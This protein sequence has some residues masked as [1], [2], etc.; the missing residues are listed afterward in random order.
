MKKVFSLLL[1]VLV[2]VSILG[3]RSAY[4]NDIDYEVQAI[5]QFIAE[6]STRQINA[7]SIRNL[8]TNFGDTHYYVV[9]CHSYRY[10]DFM[11][12]ASMWMIPKGRTYDVVKGLR[13]LHT[14]SLRIYDSAGAPDFSNVYYCRNHLEGSY[15]LYV[16]KGMASDIELEYDGGDWVT[17]SDFFDP[18]DNI[19]IAITSPRDGFKD[20]VNIFAI[21]M[22]YE[23]LLQS[24]QTPAEN[25]SINVFGG[26]EDGYAEVTHHNVRNVGGNRWQGTLKVNMEMEE[27]ENEITARLKYIDGSDEY[28]AYDTKTYYVY[29]GVV[30]ED[31]DGIDDRTGQPV[32][33]PPEASEY[34]LTAPQ[35]PEGSGI[36]GY[37]SWFFESIFWVLGM[38]TDG[39][40]RLFQQIGSFTS[41]VAEFFDFLPSEFVT[42]VFIGIM[43]SIVLRVVGR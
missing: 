18:L 38:I 29:S 13:G 5:Q 9:E 11:G 39:V 2:A 42:M 7:A 12:Y 6:N 26:K 37:I 22:F 20:N 40:R 21:Y 10:D 1:V 28:F 14:I 31:G 32:Y 8:L 43:V 41:I 35:I 15:G 17:M 25:L 33:K 4:A 19:S 24:G 27:G 36:F 30:D 23:A 3:V 16:P 34:P